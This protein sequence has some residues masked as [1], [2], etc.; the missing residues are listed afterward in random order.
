[1][2]AWYFRHVGPSWLPH[3][4]RLYRALD[5]CPAPVERP[6]LLFD[7]GLALKQMDHEAEAKDVLRA[8]VIV[9][10]GTAA[11]RRAAESLG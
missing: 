6:G 8:A 5:L 11:A 7:L 9:G 2:R 1:M 4:L 10:H 3:A